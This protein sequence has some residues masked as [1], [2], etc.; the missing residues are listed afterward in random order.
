MIVE[1]DFFTRLDLET[2]LRD[3]GAVIIGPCAK[4]KEALALLELGGSPAAAILDI[5][6]G[7]ET[8]APVARELAKRGTPF[9][10]YTGQIGVDPVLDAWP[11]CAT[12]PKPAMPA[13]IV[14]AVVALVS[15]P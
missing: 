14:A 6:L 5:R 15:A 4:V 9:L 12:L 11:D 2:T 10:F 7:R 13:A 8:V 3:A 1:D